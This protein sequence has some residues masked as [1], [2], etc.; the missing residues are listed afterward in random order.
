MLGVSFGRGVALF[1][2]GLIAGHRGGLSGWSG[3]RRLLAQLGRRPGGLSVWGCGGI[4]VE[5]LWA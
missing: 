3:A 5:L 2:M 4:E 1:L